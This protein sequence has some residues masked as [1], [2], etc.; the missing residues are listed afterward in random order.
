M[1]EELD[2]V[3]KLEDLR[4]SLV[5]YPVVH[6]IIKKVIILI[7]F[8]LNSYVLVIILI[9]AVIRNICLLISLNVQD[10]F[11]WIFGFVDL[12]ELALDYVFLFIKDLND[13]ICWDTSDEGL[14]LHHL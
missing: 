11:L 8:V 14:L 3:H 9:I 6:P 13:V 7:V 1:P 10:V 5:L 12:V 2:S 4:V